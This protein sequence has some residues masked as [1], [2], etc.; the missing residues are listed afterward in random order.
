M[1]QHGKLDPSLGWEAGARLVYPGPS[2][3]RDGGLLPNLARWSA[4]PGLLGS[5][6]VGSHSS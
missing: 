2:R 6:S 3:P 1:V 5:H 4:A